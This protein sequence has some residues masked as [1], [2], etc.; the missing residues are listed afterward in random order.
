MFTVPLASSPSAPRISGPGLIAVGLHLAVLAIG[1]TAG[2]RVVEPSRVTRVDSMVFFDRVIPGSERMAPVAA[3]IPPPVPVEIRGPDMVLEEL[4]QPE[5]PSAWATPQLSAVLGPATGR[6][7]APLDDSQGSGEEPA[8]L[9]LAGEVDEPVVVVEQG[10]PKYP[11]TLA[12]RGVSGRVVLEFV[13][14][15]TGAVEPPSLRVL[16]STAQAFEAAAREAVLATRFRPARM[17]GRPVR[18][19]ARQPVSFQA[20]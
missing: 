4:P 17:R 1:V 19:L 6:A 7:K 14:D 12:E 3:R 10:I 2:S 16:S 11:R 13:V 18:Q 15:T 8:E 5:V 20:P 9:V